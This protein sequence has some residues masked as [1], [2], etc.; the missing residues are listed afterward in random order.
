MRGKSLRNQ[1][2]NPTIPGAG[3]RKK[4]MGVDIPTARN[5]DIVFQHIAAIHAVLGVKVE[6]GKLVRALPVALPIDLNTLLNTDA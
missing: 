5:F 1:R 2:H 3:V 6:D 4:E